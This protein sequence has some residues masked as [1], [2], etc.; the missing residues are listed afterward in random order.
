MLQPLRIVKLQIFCISYKYLGLVFK[1][2]SNFDKHSKN[3]L[4][5]INKTIIFFKDFILY[6]RSHILSLF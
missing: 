1:S 6:N 3:V 2:K 4:T 5:G